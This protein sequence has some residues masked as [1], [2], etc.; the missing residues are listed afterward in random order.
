MPGLQSFFRRLPLLPLFTGI[1]LAIGFIIP[2]IFELTQ[3]PASRSRHYVMEQAAVAVLGIAILACSF[4]MWLSRNPTKQ[5][6]DADFRKMQFGLRE[7][8]V[9]MTLIGHSA[10]FE[11]PTACKKLHASDVFVLVSVPRPARHLAVNGGQISSWIFSRS[12][13]RCTGRPW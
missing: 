5:P 13:K 12:S 2:S 6:V 11:R 3:K 10:A 1:S 7:V 8:F 9:A 4:A